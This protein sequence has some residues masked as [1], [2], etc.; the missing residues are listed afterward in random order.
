LLG[1]VVLGYLKNLGWGIIWGIWDFVCGILVV[2][3]RMIMMLSGK[4]IAGVVTGLRSM[5]M[6]MSGVVELINNK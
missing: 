1:G 3:V 2:L 6:I 5:V 4:Y